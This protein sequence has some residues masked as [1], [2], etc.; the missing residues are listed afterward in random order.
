M[1]PEIQMEA[2]YHFCHCFIHDTVSCHFRFRLHNEKWKLNEMERHKTTF[3]ALQCVAIAAYHVSYVSVW[4]ASLHPICN[5]SSKLLWESAA[6]SQSHPMSWLSILL[7]ANFAIQLANN[8][9][10][11]HTFSNNDTLL[12]AIVM[13]GPHILTRDLMPFVTWNWNKSITTIFSHCI[14]CKCLATHAIPF[15]F[16]SPKNATSMRWIQRSSNFRFISNAF[17]WKGH[18]IPFF[19]QLNW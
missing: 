16:I 13:V 6:V 7:A 3:F 1:W 10:L 14:S 2:K 11:M 5:K 15:W 17:A 9:Q 8:L 4:A 12:G 18:Q 19:F